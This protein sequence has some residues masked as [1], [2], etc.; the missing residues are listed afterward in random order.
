MHMSHES[1]RVSESGSDSGQYSSVAV[2]FEVLSDPRRRSLLTYLREYGA[3]SPETIACELTEGEIN[4]S[5]IEPAATDY[6]RIHEELLSVHIPM[7]I[8]IG[9][10]E[11]TANQELVTLSVKAMVL[12]DSV[13][14]TDNGFS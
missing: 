2:L 14:N 6:G 10:I 5:G 3:E 13:E 9:L 8:D 12:F 7:L 4:G 11:H 1:M